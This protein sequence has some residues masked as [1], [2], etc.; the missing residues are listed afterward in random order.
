M[1]VVRTNATSSRTTSEIDLFDEVEIRDPEARA[2]AKRDVGEYLLEA[3]QQAVGGQESPVSGEG[4]FKK[5]SKEYAARKMD[6]VGNKDPNLELYGDMLNALNFRETSSGIELGYFGKE[7]PKAD[8]HN[9]FSGES[10]I[11]QRRHLPDTGQGFTT[12][13]EDNVRQIIANAVADTVSFDRSDFEDVETKR[14]LYEVLAKVFDGLTR[15]EIRTAVLGNQTLID[16]LE[17][18]ELLDL[19]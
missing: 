4:K 8:G 19:L 12:D 9:N 14:D 1:K 10:K 15:Y 17:E 2:K 18:L 3:I 11:P 13:I 16:L 6:E 5:L 7:A